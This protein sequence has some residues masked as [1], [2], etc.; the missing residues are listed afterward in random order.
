MAILDIFRAN[1]SATVK[2]ASPENPSSSLSNPDLWMSWGYGGNSGR[3]GELVTEQTS[4]A[5]A[6]V[7]RCVSIISG[8]IA[9]LPLKVYRDDPDLGRVESNDHRTAD[10]FGVAPNPNGG[11]TAFGW[12][13]TLSAQVL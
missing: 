3:F 6:T 10:L 9:T 13:E 1:P 5:D 11:P 7:F 8:L 4:L 2:P 12:K